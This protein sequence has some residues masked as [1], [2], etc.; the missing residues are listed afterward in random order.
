MITSASDEIK[1]LQE[2]FANLAR[3]A[4]QP[5]PEDVRLYLA[6]LIRK[7]RSTNPDLAE[8]LDQSLK[9]THT[10]S[11]GASILRRG[12]SPGLVTGG[13]IPTDG[14]TGQE[15][16]R[17]FDDREGIAVPLLDQD[18]LDQIQAVIQE[19]KGR[20]QL[21]RK[22]ISPTRSVV[23][24]GPPGVGKTLSARWI[25]NQIGKP[26]W[27][28]DLSAVMSSFLGK[29]GNNLRAALEYAKANEAVL[30]LDEFDAIAKRRGDETDV[31][32]L[33]RLVT[34]MLQEI[35]NWPDS[36]LLL[37]ATNHPELVDPALWRRFDVLLRFEAPSGLATEAAVRR[38]LDQDLKVFAP[39]LPTLS[40]SLHGRSLS[41][42]ERS[43]NMLRRGHALQSAPPEKLVKA[44][45][46]HG[47]D[48][49]SKADRLKV[50][51]QMATVGEQTY[52]EISRVTGVTR[53][54]IRKYAGPSSRK[55]RGVK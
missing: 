43:I 38:F 36:S 53:D 5:S 52:T 25:A 49:L 54:T 20:A 7:Y 19:R 45:V 9:A 4:T 33:K 22:G 55:G 14:D 30:L 11:G 34:V 8:R 50:A 23:M 18:L 24:T 47:Q 39:W 48:A 37:A 42:V 13:A 31:G 6:K 1:V 26:L 2:Q 28:L 46:G 51:I 27:V 21:L 44:L 41:D 35:D 16:V 17:V 12:S 10:R 40:L 32:E 3:L 29:T 15:L